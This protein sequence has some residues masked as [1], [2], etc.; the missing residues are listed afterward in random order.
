MMVLQIE[1]INVAVVDESAGGGQQSIA[2]AVVVVARLDHPALGGPFFGDERDAP[3][4]FL[5]GGCGPFA[6]SEKIQK[7]KSISYKS[8]G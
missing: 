6:L 2:A 1:Q 7:E 3:R 4:V 8:I 5:L